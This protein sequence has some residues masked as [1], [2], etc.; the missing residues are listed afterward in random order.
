[1]DYRRTFSFISVASLSCRMLYYQQAEAPKGPSM[2][3][4]A[5]E[6]TPMADDK[7][8]T[9]ERLPLIDLEQA[10]KRPPSRRRRLVQL[11]ITLLT[12]GIILVTFRGIIPQARP[13]PVVQAPDARS[14]P[15]PTLLL[16]TSNVNYGTL[17]IN[18]QQRT[19]RLPLL[20]P[21]LSQNY[22]ITFTPA[23]L[24]P[25][26]SHFRFAHGLVEDFRTP[27]PGHCW[28]SQP[29]YQPINGSINSNA[30]VI[31]LNLTFDRDN[32]IPEQREQIDTL[33]IQQVTAQQE[34]AIPAGSYIPTSI[35]ADGTITSTQS[36]EPLQATATLLPN[37]NTSQSRFDCGEP[38]CPPSDLDWQ[39]LSQLSGQVWVMSVPAALRWRVSNAAGNTLSDTSFPAAETIDLFL[40]YNATL[41]WHVSEQPSFGIASLADQLSN[42]NCSTALLLL[43]M[44]PQLG[45]LTLTISLDQ[46][47]GGCEISIR[48]N[49]DYQGKIIWRFGV[50]LDGDNQAHLL[51][52]NLPLAP[53]DEVAAVEQGN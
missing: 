3:Q 51:L 4:P 20:M 33:L 47:F 39:T 43:H 40:T 45:N 24:L 7:A 37:A 29:S 42:L 11:V 12:A 14:T 32:L 6:Q 41:G 2:P 28:V 1:M 25:I 13:A 50:L 46:G 38:I 18:G 34:V 26:S 8:F 9:D 17:T 19:A 27:L 52:P 15:K 53:P 10:A 36:A 21:A 22:D 30:L 35:A 49:R 16:I 44:Q 31:D 23:P 5:D 48:Q